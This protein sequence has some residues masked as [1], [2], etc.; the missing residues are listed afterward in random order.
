MSDKKR[1]ANFSLK[2]ENILMHFVK[3]NVK[4]IE[5]KKTDSNI[6]KLK[7]EIWK[8]IEIEFNNASGENRREAMALRKK[9]EN[10]K[11]N[12]KKKI[13]DNKCYN[14]GT[15]GGPPKEE[16]FTEVDRDVEEILGE[17]AHGHE[18]EFGGD[19]YQEG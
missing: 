14:R 6:N 13:A 18:S 17:R 5:N 1:S 15:G 9:Y 12:T 4:I 7:S 2:E 3:K 16:N 11:K 19:A 10:I 8:K